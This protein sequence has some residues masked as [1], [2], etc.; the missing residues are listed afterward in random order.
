MS[1]SPAAPVL[2]E[3]AADVRAARTPYL[4]LAL[5]GLGGLFNGVTGPLVSTFIPPIVQEIL[6]DRRTAI[7]VVMTI[8]NVLLLLLVP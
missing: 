1:A 5:V 3:T 4:L 7:G 8:D 6:G 2:L